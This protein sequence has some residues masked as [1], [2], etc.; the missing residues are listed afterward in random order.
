VRSWCICVHANHGSG[1]FLRSWILV[2]QISP[3][4]IP[5]PLDKLRVVN[6]ISNLCLTLN[7]SV[8]FIITVTPSR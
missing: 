6:A 1:L 3:E 7:S 4:R 5:F 2:R 8:N